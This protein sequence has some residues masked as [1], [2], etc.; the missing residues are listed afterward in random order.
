MAVTS[1]LGYA[2]DS[3]VQVADGDRSAAAYGRGPSAVA[4]G[5]PNATAFSSARV[6]SWPA[7]YGYGEEVDTHGGLF[8]KASLPPPGVAAGCRGVL[9][10]PA[11]LSQPGPPSPC[12]RAGPACPGQ[13]GG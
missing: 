1:E 4:G 7:S 8:S 11:S 2:L 6:A 13:G 12:S 9:C 10:P 5:L 3:A